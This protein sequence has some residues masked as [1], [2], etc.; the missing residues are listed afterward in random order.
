MAEDI[1]K[2]PDQNVAESLQRITGVMISRNNGEG[3]K[4]S[5]RGMGPQFN[6][7][8]VNNRTIATTDRGREFNFQS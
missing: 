1:G 3:S 4:I 7:V 2:F 5:V 8:K 6:A